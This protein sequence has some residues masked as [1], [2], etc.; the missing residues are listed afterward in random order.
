MH[1]KGPTIGYLCDRFSHS[2]KH[3][4]FSQPRTRGRLCSKQNLLQSGDIEDLVRRTFLRR[5]DA[6]WRGGPSR[7]I[8]SASVLLSPPARAVRSGWS[9]SLTPGG[10]MEF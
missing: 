2:Q 8:A 5:L 4:L 6:L 9:A 1:N 10:G 3:L 7:S